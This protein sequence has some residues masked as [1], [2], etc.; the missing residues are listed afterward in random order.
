MNKWKIGNIH[1]SV[2]FKNIL[3]ELNELYR[4]FCKSFE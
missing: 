3:L 2:K 4:N 1:L